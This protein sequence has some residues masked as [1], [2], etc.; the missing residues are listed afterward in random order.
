VVACAATTMLMSD[1]L[2]AAM[3]LIVRFCSGVSEG[4]RVDLPLPWNRSCGCLDLWRRCPVRI[5]FAWSSRLVVAQ[6]MILS[7]SSCTVAWTCRLIRSWW[8]SSAQVLHISSSELIV[9]IEAASL[10]CKESSVWHRPTQV[11]L[12]CC[13][14]VFFGGLSSVKS[15]SLARVGVMT[16]TPAGNLDDDSRLQQCVCGWLCAPSRLS[17]SMTVV[18]GLCIDFWPISR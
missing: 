2:V 12:G 15:E 3:T 14:E 6:S 5:I 17:C 1:G 9:R 8:S 16:M 18:E 7:E 13:G 4:L 11:S 10:L